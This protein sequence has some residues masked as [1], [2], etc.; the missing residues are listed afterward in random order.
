MKFG[1]KKWEP[2]G[3]MLSLREEI[4]D[5]FNDFFRRVPSEGVPREGLWYPAIDIE[6]TQDA[7]KLSAELP[8]MKKDEIKISFSD[9]RLSIEGERKLEKE[10]KDKTYHRI[11]RSY[12]RFKRM[13]SIPREVQ[14]DKA[15][16]AYEQ[17]ILTI[18]LPKSEKA[19]PKEIGISVK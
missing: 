11:E 8:G 16:A 19:K 18:T 3:D 2:F 1:I 4:D 7:F 9:G 12:G 14:A 10:E 15:I 17:G 5:L 13:V 6:E